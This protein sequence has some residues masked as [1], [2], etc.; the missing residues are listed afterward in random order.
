LEREHRRRIKKR[1]D[2]RKARE[3]RR[4]INAGMWYRGVSSWRGHGT[5][6]SR[7]RIKKREDRR[8]VREHRRKINAGMW[9]WGVGTGYLVVGGL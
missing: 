5:Q 7:R 1:E 9:Y 6:K 8:K 3:H 2:L 4:K